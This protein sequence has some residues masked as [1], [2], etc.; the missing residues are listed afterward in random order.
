[1]SIIQSNTILFSKIAPVVELTFLLGTC[2]ICNQVALH[3]LQHPRSTGMPDTQLA[4]AVRLF[5]PLESRV[6]SRFLQQQGIVMH[7][8][9]QARV[10]VDVSHPHD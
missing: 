3:N 7:G 10:V 8:S 9:E 1:M 4:A 6:G 2:P 5:G